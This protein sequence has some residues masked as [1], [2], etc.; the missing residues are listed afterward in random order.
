M[1]HKLDHRTMLPSDEETVAL[2]E[3]MVDAIAD[4]GVGQPQGRVA[5]ALTLVCGAMLPNLARGGSQAAALRL[6]AAYLAAKAD[7]VDER[8]GLN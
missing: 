5:A 6:S 8:R 3:A 7:H 2:A 4:L 1:V